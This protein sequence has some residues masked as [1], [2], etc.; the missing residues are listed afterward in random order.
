MCTE[1]MR[2]QTID[3][4]ENEILFPK[5]QIRTL[6][7]EAERAGVETMMNLAEQNEQLEKRS[8]C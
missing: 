8:W 3:L 7:L 6:C 2:D 1:S 5:N 4:I